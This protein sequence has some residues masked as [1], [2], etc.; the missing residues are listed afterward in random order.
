MSMESERDELRSLMAQ[1][2]RI[3]LTTIPPYATAAYT[4]CEVGQYD[5]IA[6]T[7]VNAEPLEVIRQVM[8]EEMLHMTLAANIL[9]A[10]GGSVILNQPS[11]IPS[12]PCR[13]LPSGK[14]PEV[15]L[16][17]FSRD[18]VRVFRE[19]ERAPV[20]FDK[21]SNGDCLRAETIGGFY[22]CV[23]EKLRALCRTHRPDQVFCG[24]PAWQVGAEHY[25][26]AGGQAFAVTD[27]ASALRAIDM[28]VD[29]GEGAD[30]GGRAGDGDPVPGTGEE[31]VAHFFK[32]NEILLSRY[33]RAD[34]HLGSPPTGA[35]LAVDWSA[36]HPM[37]DDPR[38]EDFAH[39]P[40]VHARMLAFDQ[41]YTG[42]LLALHEAFNG[43]PERLRE[44]VP[45]MIKLRHEAM[46]LVRIPVNDQGE[47]AGPGW[48]FRPLSSTSERAS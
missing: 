28:I 21:L 24:D 12:Y 48:T 47:T 34:D 11:A 30:L 2:I 36:V 35:D 16:R 41:L 37:R 1:A 25:W 31:D 33:Y 5:R 29:E 17:R 14:G 26:G 4:I 32:F 38:A 39:L 22:H 20:N 18:Q 27:E 8:I 40:E 13:L 23:R 15:R 44:A 7:E 46:A 42:F 43:R 3:E 10:L 9:N 19:I 6:P 45:V